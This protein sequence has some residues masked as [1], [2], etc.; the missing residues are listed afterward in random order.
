MDQ[1][2][3]SSEKKSLDMQGQP[4]MTVFLEP[5]PRPGVLGNLFS[6]VDSKSNQHIATGTSTSKANSKIQTISCSITDVI[7]IVFASV[8]ILRCVT[9]IMAEL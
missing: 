2:N 9:T 7:P 8:Y 1:I 5:H 6:I 3:R 4:K